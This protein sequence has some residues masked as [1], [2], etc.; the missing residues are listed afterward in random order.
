[1][2]ILTKNQESRQFGPI[3]QLAGQNLNF[4]SLSLTVDSVESQPE[5]HIQGNYGN[6]SRRTLSA[7]KALF[8]FYRNFSPYLL[9]LALVYFGLQT[10]NA[11]SSRHCSTLFLINLSIW[12]LLLTRCAILFLIH[13]SAFPAINTLYGMPLYSLAIILMVQSLYQL[14]CQLRSRFGKNRP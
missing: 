9:S 2:V 10:F 5:T 13:I 1:M 7:R 14:A 3:M 4:G 11:L 8:N 6:D 12:T